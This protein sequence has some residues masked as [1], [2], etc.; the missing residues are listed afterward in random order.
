MLTI[1]CKFCSLYYQVLWSRS[2]NRDISQDNPCLCM[3]ERASGQKCTQRGD[4]VGCFGC[5]R[6]LVD[7]SLQLFGRAPMAEFTSDAAQ[8]RKRKETWGERSSASLCIIELCFKA[9][10]FRDFI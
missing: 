9:I 2:R 5:S 10:L 3:L 7:G 1:T 4:V 6:P 8:N